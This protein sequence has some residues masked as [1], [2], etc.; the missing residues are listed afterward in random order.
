MKSGYQLTQ[1]AV[2]NPQR[3]DDDV[4]KD[5]FVIRQKQFEY[6]M[7]ELK[8]ERNSS[9][10]Q[11]HIVIGARGM[12][13]STLLKRIEIELKTK[14]YKQFVPILYPEE[15]YNITTLSD[16]WLNTLDRLADYLDE[17]GNDELTERIDEEVSKFQKTEDREGL[18]DAIFVFIQKIV[19]KLKKR[20]VL[21]IDNINILFDRLELNEQH[22]LRNVL[23]KNGV[24]I[25]IGGSPVKIDALLNYGAPFY[26]AFEI[27]YLEKITNDDLF[28]VLN[29]LAKI[30]SSE[31][32]QKELKENSARLKVINQ[33]TGG[34][35]RTAVML[36][37]LISNGFSESLVQDL[38]ALLDDITPLYKARFEEELSPQLQIIMNAIALNWH[39]IAIEQLREQTGLSNAKLSP[40][41]KR[42]IDSGWIIKEK[43]YETKGHIYSVNERFFNIWYLM[44]QSSRRDKK[45]ITHLARF[46]EGLFGD[47]IS[48][49]AELLL[50]QKL[51]SVDHFYYALAICHSINDV[52][53][54]DE[55]INKC[56]LEIENLED[57]LQ[58]EEL[59]ALITNLEE[60]S[61]LGQ[62]V[63]DFFSFLMNFDSAF[64]DIRA[65]RLKKAKKF[66]DESLK[67][68]K[69]M[70][71]EFA[72]TAMAYYYEEGLKDYKSAEEWYLSCIGTEVE[73]INGARLANIYHYHL[74][75]YDKAITWYEKMG[76]DILVSKYRFEQAQLLREKL[77]DSKRAREILNCEEDGTS[78]KTLQGLQLVLCDLKDLNFGKANAQ[79]KWLL[80]LVKGQ[81][82]YA[83]GKAWNRF[84]AELKNANQLD[85]L[86][87]VLES[88]GNDKIMAPYYS[89]IKALTLDPKHHE[90]YLKTVAVEISKPAQE[91]LDEVIDIL[92]N[93]Y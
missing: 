79:M 70:V 40:Q 3:L 42:L 2:Y 1:L 71:K 17:L 8:D 86:T 24:P 18:D 63:V 28:L 22:K 58:K 77:N 31:F 20:P 59:L 91:I 37:K 12:G 89:A 48:I 39:P 90:S 43:G 54:K 68:D 93:E 13:K 45:Q 52:D 32:I 21:L 73:G 81:I 46:L 92:E 49:Q 78:F 35:P 67:S 72:S 80:K 5:F 4:F 74:K 36:F 33:L 26:D 10:P 69:T 34:N 6:L 30:T 65:G 53:L 14:E 50:G 15:Q 44:R 64:E 61:S 19:K 38:D 41:L 57:P 83:K 60:E 27:Q 85:W 51:S 82:G 47:Q 9:I 66:I 7:E 23:S 29:N 62:I 75:N 56:K 55:L 88:T 84:T 25:I 11:H 87:S 76:N 16:F